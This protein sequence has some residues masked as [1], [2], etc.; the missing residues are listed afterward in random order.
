M[1]DG[2]D[3]DYTGREIYFG[4]HAHQVVIADVT[5]KL[6][7]QTISIFNYP[8][9]GYTHQNWVDEDHKYMYLGDE[10]DELDFGFNKK[11]K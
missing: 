9:T 5:D 8:T 3:S 10:G 1:Y 2:P 6:N 4:S 7:P 11:D